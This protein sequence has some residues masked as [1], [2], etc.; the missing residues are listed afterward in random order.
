MAT[1]DIGLIDGQEGGEDGA[2]MIRWGEVQVDADGSVQV[3][4]EE[5]S[6]RTSST[7]IT[8]TTTIM[9]MIG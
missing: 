1:S 8:M 7:L 9:M 3:D 6:R 4:S 2:P 5:D